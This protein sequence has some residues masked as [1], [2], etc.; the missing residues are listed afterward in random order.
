MNREPI[1]T[2]G[3]MLCQKALSLHEDFSKETPEGSDAAIH[4]E[5]GMVAEIQE[6]VWTGKYKSY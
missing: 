5:E 6:W 1:P 2:G 3:N 4:C